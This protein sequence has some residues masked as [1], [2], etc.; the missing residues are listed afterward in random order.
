MSSH[1]S[2][3]LLSS[4][5]MKV[6][7]FSYELPEDLSG[8]L[9]RLHVHSQCRKHHILAQFISQATLAVREE[10]QLLP[11][12]LRCLVPLFETIFSLA[13]YSDLRS[14]PLAGSMD[15][16]LLCGFQIAT[17]IGYYEI[18]GFHDVHSGDRYLSG[19]GLGLISSLAASLAPDLAS[20][21]TIGA[22]VVRIAFRLGVV[23]SEVSN[24]LEPI[25]GQPSHHHSS[26]A[27][28]V[29]DVVPTDVQNEL[30]V[31]HAEKVPLPVFAGL[32]HAKHIYDNSYTAEI[33]QTSSI[34]VID[35]TFTPQTAIFCSSNGQPMQAWTA[36]TLFRDV[37]SEILTQSIHWEKVVQ[38]IMQTARGTA[39]VKFQLAIFQPSLADHELMHTLNAEL[40]GLKTST[41]NLASW[42]TAD[43]SNHE[44][45]ANDGI[46][47]VGMSCRLPGGATDTDTFWA[48]LEQGLDVHR[49]VPADRFDVTTH[50]DPSGK[51]LNASWTPYGCFIDEPGLFD[52]AIFN[53]S[54]REAVQT[55][56]MQRLALA[57]AYE[58][59]E[60]AGFVLNRTPSSR[61]PCVGTSYGQASDDYREVNTG[62]EIGTYFITGGCRAFGPGRINYF[63]KFSGPSYSI[64]TACSS[65][66]A[67]IQVACTTLWAGDADTIVAGGVNVLT[68]SDAFAGLSNGHFLSSTPNACKTWD[69]EADGY[70]RADGVVSFVLKRL[71]DAKADNDTI[72]GVI[73]G[74]G[75]NHSA[76]AV[77]ITHPHAPSQAYLM[78]QVL[79]Q[80]GVDPLDVSYAWPRA[81]GDG[82]KRLA[83]MNNFS[84]AGGN[85]CLLLE[86]AP[87]KTPCKTSDPR[88]V[89]TVAVSAKSKQSLLGNLERLVAYLEAHPQTSMANVGYTTTARRHHYNHRV[90]VVVSDAATA[91]AKLRTQLTL[92]DALKPILPMAPPSVVFA[93]TGQGASYP[94]MNVELF[95]DSPAFQAQMLHLDVLV[96]KQGFP[97]IVPALDGSHV[98]S[99]VHSPVV[100]Q[101]AL[102]CVEIALVHYWAGLG[103]RP[104]VV[105]GHSLGEYA[106]LHA[107]GVLSASDAIFLVGKRAQLL[108]ELCEVGS[109]DMLAVRASVED[110]EA[111]VGSGDYEVACL[112]SPRDTVL[113]GSANKIGRVAHA[114]ETRGIKRFRLDVSF[115][116]HSSQTDPVLDRFEQAACAGAVTFHQPTL[117]VISPLLGRV[118]FDDKTV[119][120]RYI[121]QATREPVRFHE[122]LG[123]AY[124]MGIIDDSMAWVEDGPHPVCLGFVKSTLTAGPV[125]S[126]PSLR[127]GENSWQTQA[128]SLAVLHNAGL[129]VN[130]DEFHRPFEPM[131]SLMD[132]PTY[133]WNDKTYW[134]QYTGVWALTKGNTFYTDKA[135]AQKPLSPASSAIQT[136]SVQRVVQDVFMTTTAKV[137][138][139]SD[140]MQ[141][142]LLAATYGHRMNNCGVVT[143]SIHA[144]IAFTLG[145]YLLDRL[146][147]GAQDTSIDIANLQ[148]VKGLVAYKDTSV[149]QVIQVSVVVDDVSTLSVARLAWHN[150]QADKTL[151]ELPFATAELHFGSPAGWLQAWS[152]LTHLVQGRIDE[153]TRLADLGV[154]NRLSRNMANTLFAGSL[155]DYSEKYRG[156][157]SVVLHGLEAYADVTLSTASLKGTWTIPPD[158]I[159]S[160]AHLAG[161]VMNVSDAHDTH[162]NFSVTPGWGS[163]RLAVPLVAGG[164]YRS[165]VKMVPTFE[166]PRI[167]LGDVYVLRALDGVIIGVVGAIEFRQYPRLLL[168]RF[169][170]ADAPTASPGS[171]QQS[172]K[173]VEP[174]APP[175]VPVVQST[176]APA[177]AVA[178]ENNTDSTTS[179]AIALVAAEAGIELSELQDDVHFA[180]VG[181]DSLMSLVISERFREQLG[182]QV[183]G[184]LFLEYPTVG[185]LRAW[186]A[187]YYG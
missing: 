67:A 166:D 153:L 109:H 22:E 114:L 33:I 36:R 113:S 157:Q 55:D 65:G 131:L 117:P 146:R 70:C 77:S 92:V 83:L 121:R 108:T 184:S 105:L 10:V 94:S 47:I 180:H 80:A 132:L 35:T 24:N 161:F 20:L 119:N 62:Q 6:I 57:T 102:V 103:I 91:T 26:W 44:T 129:P 58:A 37:V 145:R 144:D 86:E 149:P 75:T 162:A 32:C 123:V 110:I 43:D 142:E 143:S 8:L 17:L 181:V 135:E 14:G 76:D 56:P 74:A 40:V 85:N 25:S 38:G 175:P 173:P 127:R 93:F 168:N 101:L 140:L 79:A 118:I 16:V 84:A 160:V 174:V 63:F 90:A 185:H 18:N 112:N 99:H 104:D 59:L 46:A 124:N 179:K 51:S 163:M 134:H 96:Q 107:A 1:T 151:E 45:T 165:Y 183:R 150:V 138:I 2:E 170:S 182:V 87:A 159:D 156:M 5:Q 133:A 139:Q 115:A 155:V 116:F 111:A 88:P 30:E 61:E 152:P 187:E 176:S 167:F 82:K 130:W 15:G 89:H 68:N 136:T 73:G 28:V 154:A 177:P 48:I 81:L 21:P 141:P 19:L 148:V 50:C 29:P 128:L 41:K 53:M 78:R 49:T 164:Q 34:D 69:S 60:R 23:V 71:A 72:L 3:S 106:A 52:A 169:F 126:V 13:G 31:Y 66:L 120:A 7:Y 186:L 11:A 95:H 125:A 54:P 137:V 12:S 97:S 178:A 158:F 98:R 27:Y 42:I 64:D 39:A 147:P 171:A 9:R 172:T 100:T 4:G 122:A